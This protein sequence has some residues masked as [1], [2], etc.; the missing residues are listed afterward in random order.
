MERRTFIQATA[1]ALA[2]QGYLPLLAAEKKA[3]K[4]PAR[5]SWGNSRNPYVEPCAI[6][7]ITGVLPTFSPVAGAAMSGVFSAQYSLLAWEMAAEKSKNRPMGSMKV[8]FKEGACHTFET[9][10]GKG[11]APACSIKTAVHLGKKKTAS[12]WT[13]ESQVDGRDHVRLIEEGAWDG[14]TMTVK[15][16]SFSRQYATTNPLIH[17]W[18]LLPLLASGEIKKKPL[19]FDML[20]DSALRTNQ[21]LRHEGEIEIPVKG[22]SAT[23]DSYVQTGYGVLPIHYLVDGK[24]RV[25]LITQSTVNWVLAGRRG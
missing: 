6:E 11:D 17:R 10:D 13:L 1:A 15:G 20:D 18:S 16:K 5:R 21:T 9:R 19:V 7:P 23:V 14:K 12:Q 25:Q 2:A 22:G 3:K 8:N 4:A 24:G